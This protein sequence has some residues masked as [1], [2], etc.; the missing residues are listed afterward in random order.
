MD[1][2]VT[3]SLAHATAPLLNKISVGHT[4]VTAASDL[5]TEAIGKKVTPF[6]ISPSD[7]EFEKIFNSYN[8][9]AAIYFSRPL[10]SENK[11]FDEY[12][13]LSECL[14]ICSEHDV[15]QFIFVKPKEFS[16]SAQLPDSDK[17]VMLSSCCELCEYYRKRRAMSVIVLNA[18]ELYGYN[19]TASVI[20]SAVSQAV[21][22][23]AIRFNAKREQKIC[24]L[25][26]KDMGELILRM[27]DN[28]TND[29]DY[30]D[31]PPADII[32]F[33]EL[34]DLFK[35]AFPTVRISYKANPVSTDTSFSSAEIRREY[36]W[37]PILSISDEIDNAI[38][39]QS[40]ET[41]EEKK[42]VFAKIGELIKK[43]S[44]IVK[45][46]ELLLGFLLMELLNRVTSTTIQFKYI[47]FRLLYIVIMGTVHGMKTGLGAA[48]LASLS[49]LAASIQNHNNWSAVVYDIDILSSKVPE[50][51]VYHATSTGYGGMLAALGAWKND[52]PSI[53]TEHGIYTREREEEILR[54]KWIVPEFRQQWINMFFMLSHCAYD[55][56]DNVTALFKRYA[57]IQEELGC[58]PSKQK[59]I[60]NGIRTERFASVLTKKPNGYIDI[61][62]VVRIHPIKDI[63][64]M[65]H[66]FFALKQRIPNVRLHILGDTDDKEYGKECTD[67]IE[68]LNISDI[69]MPGNV[70][71][72]KYLALTD[73]TVL[74]SISE[75]QPLAVLESLA[76]GIPCVT[77]DVG[78]CNELIYG[79]AEDN[80][81][82]AGIVVP[83]M[84]SQALANALE[85]MCKNAKRRREM[86]EAGKRR[87]Q[88][89]YVH[90]DMI[91][92]YNDNYEE[93]LR[94][95]QA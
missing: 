23:A 86:G 72:I 46:A 33:G 94:G 8:F 20:G 82:D 73:F 24:L 92:N 41:T 93:V 58:S 49:L 15:N 42:G 55:R 64:T 47:D 51:D 18:P 62:A 16:A 70:D 19:E 75:G 43:H 30:I 79:S 61:T 81:G 76:A 39:A 35:I 34:G 37:T 38:A 69:D 21:S 89:Y 65:I 85:V 11:G 67:L 50:A 22:D 71:V 74:S 44:F 60:S 2:L 14:K 28:W 5:Q 17:G 48:G 9:R 77:T 63:K 13:N 36:D 66:A 57:E 68:Q 25:S 54:A 29:Y 3:G 4:V 90:E 7:E 10:F 27:I 26:Q 56:A 32:S 45:T 95:W 59:V 53:I 52:R 80:F 83:P 91:K 87:V 1:I 84:H 40:G 31:V 12:G 88:K 78:C 6:R